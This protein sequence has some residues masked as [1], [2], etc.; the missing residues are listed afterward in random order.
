MRRESELVREVHQPVDDLAA[1][2]RYLGDRLPTRPDGGRLDPI[3]GDEAVGRA[4]LARYLD[5][6]LGDAL[7]PVG[8]G[9]N[10]QHREGVG[11]IAGRELGAAPVDFI[12]AD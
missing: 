6:L 10:H 9:R 2:P 1:G 11:L 8:G 12:G 7:E 3:L 5:D 4:W